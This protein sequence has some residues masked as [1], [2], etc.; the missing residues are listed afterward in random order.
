MSEIPPLNILLLGKIGQLGSELERQ[1]GPLGNLVVLDYPE[2]D[3]TH[4]R[5]AAQIVAKA[6]P[7]LIVNAVAYTNVDKAE[8]EHGTCDLINCESVIEIAKT[9]RKI[10]A[11]LIHV[12]TDYVFDGFKNAPYCEDDPTHPL[13]YY[14]LSKMNAEKGIRANTDAFWIFRTA[15][16]YSLTRDDFVSKVLKWSRSQ[17]QMRVV[18]DQV[19]SPTWASMLAEKIVAA[20]RNGGERP[21]E[22]LRQTQGTYHLAGDGVASR[23]EW[24]RKILELDP[25]REEQ[26]VSDL[27][28]AATTDFPTP[29]TRPLYTA[30]DCS[31]FKNTFKLELPAWD[32]SLAAAMQRA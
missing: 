12:S 18:A 32:E 5:D 9:A 26:V 10:G 20:V 17:A 21:V 27:I 1:L 24:V 23:L 11:G 15:W 29:A 14:G 31:K 3:F 28:P 8:T 6:T 16:L 25:H 22:Y 2:I 7:D 30:L 4:P 19:G 13:N